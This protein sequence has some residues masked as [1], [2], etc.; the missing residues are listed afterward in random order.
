MLNTSVDWTNCYN[1]VEGFNTCLA[2]SGSGSLVGLAVVAVIVLLIGLSTK[3]T[4]R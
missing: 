1:A 4:R 2:Q 3:G